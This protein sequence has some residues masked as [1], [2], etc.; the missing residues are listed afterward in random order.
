MEEHRYDNPR[1]EGIFIMWMTRLDPVIE[2]IADKDY[3]LQG[4]LGTKKLLAS[5]G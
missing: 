3:L 2:Y 1:Q 4:I 5:A